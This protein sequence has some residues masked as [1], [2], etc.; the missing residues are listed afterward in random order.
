MNRIKK[1]VEKHFNLKL[2]EQT[3]RFEVVFARGCY[4]KICREL[5]KNSFQKIGN[6]LGKNHATVMHGI[7]TVNDLIETDKD[8]KD[9]FN[10]LLNKFSEYN[11]IKEKMNITQLV[12][13]YNKLLLLCGQK[14]AKINELT[15]TIYRLADLD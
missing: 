1:I 9:Q 2:D 6:T 5:T 11:K 4:F 13:E 15:E 3:R 12:R 10:Q 14:D 8:L 7:K